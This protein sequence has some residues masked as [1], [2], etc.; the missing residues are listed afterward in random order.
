[1]L[2]LIEPRNVAR[3]DNESL[4]GASEDEAEVDSGNTGDRVRGRSIHFE[5]GKNKRG[6]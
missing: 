5:W 2:R 1:M 4:D 6:E 3:L